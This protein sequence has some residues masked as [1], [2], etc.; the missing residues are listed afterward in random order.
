M[1]YANVIFN[2]SKKT[3]IATGI[4]EED[5]RRFAAFAMKNSRIV[6]EILARAGLLEIAEDKYKR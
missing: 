1:Y 4:I 6:F 2:T 3:Y 5:K